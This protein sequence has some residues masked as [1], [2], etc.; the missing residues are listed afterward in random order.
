MP[1]GYKSREQA[2]Y[3]FSLTNNTFG[4]FPPGGVKQLQ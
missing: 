4:H 3:H 1:A 2:V